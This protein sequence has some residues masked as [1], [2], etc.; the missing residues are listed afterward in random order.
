MQVSSTPATETS[1]A[2]LISS[3]IAQVPAPWLVPC[4]GI[5]RAPWAATL[6][7]GLVSITW[8]MSIATVK[9]S[10]I[11]IQLGVFPNIIYI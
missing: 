9:S 11:V 3:V 5:E 2:P 8:T 6:K 10:T 7:S 4:S 1:L